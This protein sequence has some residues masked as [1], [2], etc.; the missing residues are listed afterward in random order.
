MKTPT[1]CFTALCLACLTLF[2]QEPPAAAT[3]DD[4]FLRGKTPEEIRLLQTPKMVSVCFETFSMDMADAA[5]L[6]REAPTDTKLYEEISTRVSKGKAKLEGVMI[7]RARSGERA[8]VENVSETIYPAGYIHGNAPSPQSPA[9]SPKGGTKPASDKP[10]AAEVSPGPAA[11]AGDFAPV[12][13]VSFQTRH[14]GTTLQ[15]EPTISGDAR[16]IVDLRIEPEIVTQVPRTSWG[17]G[18]SEAEV[19]VF[20][21]QKI[22]TAATLLPGQPYLLGT[23]SRPPGSKADPDGSQRIWLAFVTVKLVYAMKEE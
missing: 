16:Q 8:I 15:I 3:Q 12:L 7:A 21:S 2:A 18:V 23:P 17:Q 11:Q 4:P 14:V 10:D 5:A 6:Y 9:L 20:E 1:H 22:E 19:P 13:P